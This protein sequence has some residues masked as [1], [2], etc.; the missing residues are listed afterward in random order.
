MRA[1]HCR[2]GARITRYIF[3][4]TKIYSIHTFWL[5]FEPSSGS[6]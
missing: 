3:S 2:K 1:K 5:I 4:N 6:T